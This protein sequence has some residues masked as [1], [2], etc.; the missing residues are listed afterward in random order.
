[1]IKDELLGLHD[2]ALGRLLGRLAGMTD[3]EFFWEPAPNCWTVRR[4]DDGTAVAD[5]GVIFE[6]APPVTTLAWRLAHIADF[7]WAE[8]CATWL[9][10][11][12]VPRSAPH[13][14]PTSAVAAIAVVRRAG[15]VFRR[16]LVEADGTRLTDPLGAIAG[17]FRDQTG[18]GFVL[19]IL[20]ELIHHGA[21]AGL[22][23]DL[24]RE[25]RPRDALL[26]ALLSGDEAF[27]RDRQRA[28]PRAVERVRHSHPDLVRTAAE[29]G[30]LSVIPWLVRHGFTV[31]GDSGR[32]PLH[33][34]AAAGDTDILRFLIEHGAN[35][36][37]RDPDGK[38]AR[39]WAEF[40]GQHDAVA[41]LTEP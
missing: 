19:H 33:H 31:Q 9:G 10:L 27:V 28:D 35:L 5:G 29:T 26:D 24:Y 16:Y 20:D 13:L 41:V 3:E 6:E 36:D 38:T 37:A 25:S 14:V 22:L 40:F 18:T 7:L 4:R 21:E 8:R 1:M 2:F 11:T 15:E 30:R 23:R 39:D 17:P 34:A 32:T 12:P